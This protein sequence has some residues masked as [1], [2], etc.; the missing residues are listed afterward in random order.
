MALIN[1][2]KIS[3]K[4]KIKLEID[5]DIYST[6]NKYCEWAGI[7]DINYFF[8]EAI[9]FVFSKD[10]DWKKHLKSTTE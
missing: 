4:E 5:K 7:D 6:I 2:K 8:E 10:S 3:D 1:A 9:R